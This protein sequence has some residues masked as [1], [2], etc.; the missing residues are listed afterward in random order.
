MGDA[1]GRFY[2]VVSPT[3]RSSDRH[4]DEWRQ[5]RVGARDAFVGRG[6]EDDTC[7]RIG[8]KFAGYPPDGISPGDV[9]LIARADQGG[10]TVVGFGVVYG[11]AL[12]RLKGVR[13]PEAFGVAVTTA[14]ISGL[15]PLAGRCAVQEGSSQ[16][17]CVR[18][19]GSGAEQCASSDRSV[20]VAATAGRQ[21]RYREFARE[22]DWREWPV[23]WWQAEQR[24]SRSAHA[25]EGFGRENIRIANFLIDAGDYNC[26]G[27]S[28]SLYRL[29]NV[30]HTSSWP[31]C[32]SQL[33]THQSSPVET[34][35]IISHFG[36]PD[37][38][39]GTPVLRRGPTRE[40][41]SD[42]VE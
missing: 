32:T 24:R 40:H 2:W 31:A 4:S 15:E 27:S 33:D 8:P 14:S 18:E 21:Q 13:A 34:D 30:F 28:V 16:V 35:E 38:I 39:R 37:R 36:F 29:R 7:G 22:T 25:Q 17:E 26:S 19:I 12:T 23:G 11:K 1:G 10:P 42:G 3:L 6:T 9:I 41:A 5:A 20:G